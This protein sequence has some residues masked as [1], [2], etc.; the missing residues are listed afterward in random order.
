[1]ISQESKYT[2]H[3]DG[4]KV[5]VKP[6]LNGHTHYPGISPKGRNLKYYVTYHMV[7]YAGKVCTIKIKNDADYYYI[8]EL[9]DCFMWSQSMFDKVIME[10]RL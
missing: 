10:K 6:D 3:K 1:M 5:R 7:A 4:Q 9:G 2:K 8:E